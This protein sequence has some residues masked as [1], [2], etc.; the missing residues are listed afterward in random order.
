MSHNF[1]DKEQN[2]ICKFLCAT[3]ICNSFILC[4]SFADWA[5]VCIHHPP[6]KFQ[7]LENN[8]TEEKEEKNR[9]TVI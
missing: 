8:A 1:T 7:K 4:I 3:F 9:E 6:F 5:A 2:I